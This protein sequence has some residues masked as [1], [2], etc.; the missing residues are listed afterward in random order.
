MTAWRHSLLAARLA[1]LAPRA[2]VY[3]AL[4]ILSAAGVRA[5]VRPLPTRAA[6]ARATGPDL[7]AQAFAQSFVRDYLTFDARDQDGYDRRVGG[8]LSDSLAAD[9]ELVVAPRRSQ[10]VQWTQV[11]GDEPTGPGRRTIVVEAGTGG[12]PAYVA[13]A[14]SRASGGALFVAGYPALVGPPAS[15]PHAE[16]P[17]EADVSDPDL[18]AVV[19]RA[20]GNYLAGDISELRAD[21]TSDAAVAP[22]SQPLALRSV[23]RISWAAPR[24]AAV[25]VTAAAPD[26]SVW[27]L[28]YELSVVRRDRWYVAAVEIDP[29]K[30]GAS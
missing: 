9:A 3:V 10:R 22:P 8:Y 25:T 17:P 2:A 28:R 4:A 23:D 6:P 27:T 29:R 14:V 24:T 16:P 18:Q 11:V 7:P 13:V 30:E 26:G 20:V 5:I 1:G 21:L 15:D 12:A 19:R